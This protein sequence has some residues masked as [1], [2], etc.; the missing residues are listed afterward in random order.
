MMRAVASPARRKLLRRGAELRRKMSGAPHRVDYFHQV[1][2]PYSHLA[3][4]AFLPL[5]QRYEIELTPHLAAAPDDNAVPERELFD[6]FARRDAAD[7]APHFGVAFRDPG[8]APAAPLVRRAE[9][10]LAGALASARFGE[11]ATQVGEALWAGDAE[12]LE[13]LAEASPPADE[14]D[15][16]RRIT[17]GT[18]RRTSM[19]HYLNA[20]FHYGDE[21]YWGVDRLGYLEERLRELDVARAEGGER[22]FAPPAETCAANGVFFREPLNPFFPADDQLIVLP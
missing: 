4:Q 11:L 12:A 8:R 20:T 13:R 5:L 6:A 19:G 14:R 1:G 7:I 22:A 3:C 17:E 9:C 2:D 16:A 18:Q 15:T 10:I 21:W